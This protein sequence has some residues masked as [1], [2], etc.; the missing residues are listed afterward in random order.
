[1]ISDYSPL[2]CYSWWMSTFNQTQS[3]RQRPTVHPKMRN[4]AMEMESQFCLTPIGSIKIGFV[5][6]SCPPFPG[7]WTFGQVIV[8]SI[9]LLL[10]RVPF[11]SF[12]KRCT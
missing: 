2:V 7:T 6:S 11:Q 9:G 12:T 1:M 3:A 5:L 4:P 10:L 8:E